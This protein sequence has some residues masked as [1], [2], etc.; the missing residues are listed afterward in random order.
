MD[1][2]LARSDDQLGYYVAQAR[3][4]IDLSVM[5]QKEVVDDLRKLTRQQASL[6][7]EVN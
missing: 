7:E 1:K 3:E 5:S 4:L 6:T 2:S